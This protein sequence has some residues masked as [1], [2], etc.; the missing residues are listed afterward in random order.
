MLTIGL[1]WGAQVLEN[2]KSSIQPSRTSLAALSQTGKPVT[3][4]I[5]ARITNGESFRKS[6]LQRKTS[7][8]GM[9]KRSETKSVDEDSCS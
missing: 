6:T 3:H 2:K 8:Q 7:R 1:T 4:N 5:T 9:K